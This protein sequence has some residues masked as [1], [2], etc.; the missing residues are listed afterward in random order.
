VIR[1]GVPFD[2]LDSYLPERGPHVRATIDMAI[3]MGRLVCTTN[4]VAAWFRD[5]SMRLGRALGRTPGG[6]P[7]Y[8]D[9]STGV[10]LAGSSGAGSYF[11]QAIAAD[12]ARLDDVL[13]GDAWLLCSADLDLPQ[14]APFSKAITRWLEVHAAEAVLVRPDRHVFGSGSPD[15][16]VPAWTAAT[17]LPGPARRATNR[18]IPN[19][20]RA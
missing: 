5:Q 6:P 14:F 15:Q 9:I 7:G 13:G 20:T 8:P 11:P 10:I 12:G 18:S 4:P 17:H 2:L 19:E 16:L 3:M 1:S